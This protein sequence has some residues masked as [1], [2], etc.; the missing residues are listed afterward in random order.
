MLRYLF[1]VF[2]CLLLFSC[3]EQDRQEIVNSAS[4][5]DLDQAKASVKQSNISITKAFKETDTASIIQS[6]TEKSALMP[7][8]H[9]LIEGRDSIRAYLVKL[10]QAKVKDLKIA[11]ENLWGDSTLL[12]E[13]GT[14]QL[15]GADKKKLD[16]GKYI[17]LWM[18]ES[19]NWKIYRAMWTSDFPGN[20]LNFQD[21]AVKS[22]NAFTK[23]FGR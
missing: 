19:G 13:I 21:T 15:N 20:K 6:F 7:A 10:L 16:E 5:F 12:T 2:F 14:Y 8:H 22:K 9:P 4:A 18:R 3:S 1:Y 11:S 23:L 17:A